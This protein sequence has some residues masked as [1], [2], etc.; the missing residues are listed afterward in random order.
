MLA[1]Y[2]QNVFNPI[3]PS[4]YKEQSG[5]VVIELASDAFK[6]FNGTMIVQ[7]YRFD[8]MRPAI[9]RKVSVWGV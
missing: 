5:D 9:E 4:P 3:L 1:Y 6:N 8:S 7:V 2:M